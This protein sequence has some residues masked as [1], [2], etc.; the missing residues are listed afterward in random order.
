MENNI[1]WEEKGYIEPKK[2]CLK[3]YELEQNGFTNDT[4]NDSMNKEC[5]DIGKTKKT[6][7]QYT[8][9][10]EKNKE[11]LIKYVRKYRQENKEKLL[12]YACQYRK[13]NKKLKTLEQKRRSA[14]RCCEYYKKH[15]KQVR[16]QQ[17]SYTNNRKKT[18]INY[19]ITCILRTRLY[20]AIKN[21]QKSGSAVKDLGCSVE[22]FKQYI[23][24]KFQ[25]G[26]SWDNHGRWHLDHI[27]PLAWF[28][29]EDRN[30]FLVACHYTN[31]Q[32]LWA[33]DNYIKWAN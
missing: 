14:M 31:L 25:Q 27:T 10:R 1:L 20:N 2:N 26:M 18:D 30:Q 23:E 16:Q 22:E 33:R 6:G 19:K 12:K 24:S 28:N 3:C 4:K 8:S 17:T 5:K 29:L 15:K 11:N 32:P 7:K 21:T 13:T 9:W